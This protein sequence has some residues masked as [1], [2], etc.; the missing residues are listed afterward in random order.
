MRISKSNPPT[1]KPIIALVDMEDLFEAPG[2]TGDG[3][4]LTGDGPG[5]TGDG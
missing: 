5:L 3:P 2:L 1:D 4:G